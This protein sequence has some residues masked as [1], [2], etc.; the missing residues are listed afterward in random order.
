MA[1]GDNYSD[2]RHVATGCTALI[3][4]GAVYCYTDVVAWSTGL[5]VGQSISLSQP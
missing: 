1:Y 3:Y 5:S 4:V 2:W